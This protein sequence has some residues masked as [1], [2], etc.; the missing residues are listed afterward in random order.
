MFTNFSLETR[1]NLKYYG[2]G[3]SFF[4]GRITVKIIS[5][6]STLTQLIRPNIAGCYYVSSL[7]A[8]LWRFTAIEVIVGFSE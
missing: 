3:P 6:P 7:S 1:E 5:L 8:I 2:D 4:L